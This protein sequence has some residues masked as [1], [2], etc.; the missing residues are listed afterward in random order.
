M[1]AT[2]S[3]VIGVMT[4]VMYIREQICAFVCAR[5]VV[6]GAQELSSRSEWTKRF[7]I[8]ETTCS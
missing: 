1:N 5:H 2:S 8:V 7:G 3:G 6:L 4:E